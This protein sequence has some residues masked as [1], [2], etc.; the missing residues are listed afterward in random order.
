M[1]YVLKRLCSDGT[2]CQGTRFTHHWIRGR[3]HHKWGRLVA[4]PSRELNIGPRRFDRNE[5]VLVQI[6]RIDRG[7]GMVMEMVG[8]DH[9][10]LV[11][12][13]TMTKELGHMDCDKLKK[14]DE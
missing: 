7:Q 10:Y 3:I 11:L 4:S 1:F 8:N 2:N 12:V 13:W 6:M 9:G 14:L 5:K